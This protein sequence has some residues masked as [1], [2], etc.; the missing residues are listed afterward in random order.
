MAF[1]KYANAVVQRPSL[2]SKDWGLIR[3]KATDSVVF[4]NKT[5]AVNLSDYSSDKYLLTHAT[6]IASVDVEN[7]PNVKVGEVV[8]NGTKVN[9]KWNDY[10]ITTDTSKYVNANLDAWDRQTLLNTYRT[11]IGAENFCEHVQIPELSKGKVIDAVAR[12]LGDTIYVDILVATDRKHTELIKDIEEGKVSTLSM[13]CFLAGTPITMADGTTLPIE[14]IQPGQ[15]VLTHKGRPRKVLNT[16][17]K[18]G[19]TRIYEISSVGNPGTVK[20]TSEHPFYVLRP[21]DKCACGCGEDLEARKHSCPV[22]RVTQRFKIGHKAR[23]LN[24]N[25]SMYTEDEYASRSEKIRDI[26]SLKFEWVNAEDLREGDYVAFPKTTHEVRPKDVDERMA[27]LMG[28]FLSEGNFMKDAKGNR[29]GIEFT[30][31]ITE[32]DTLGL[33]TKN[34]LESLTDANVLTYRRADRNTFGVRVNADRELANKMYDLCGEYSHGKRLR[35]DVIYWPRDLKLALIGAYLEGDGCEGGSGRNPKYISCATVSYDLWNQMYLILTS[36]GIFCSK[37]VRYNA[38]K[39]DLEEVL[40]DNGRVIGTDSRSKRPSF[41]LQMNSSQAIKLGESVSYHTG[42]RA[43]GKTQHLR[44]LEDWIIFP[45]TSIESY[46]YE[47]AVYNFEV[48]EDNSYVAFGHAVHNCSILFSRCSKCGNV[49]ADETELC[50]HIRYEKGNFFYDSNGKK[51]IVAELCGHS[52]EADSVTFIEASWVANPAFKGAVVRNLLNG[53]EGTDASSGPDATGGFEIFANST[54][55]QEFMKTQDLETFA[56]H[57]SQQPEALKRLQS[58][59]RQVLASTAKVSFGFGD[60]DEEEEGE[61][62]PPLEELKDDIK[63]KLREDIKRDLLKEMEE[64]MNLGPKQPFFEGDS[65]K[66]NTNNNIIE[67]YQAFSSKYASELK[68]HGL[69]RNVYT[70]VF[71]A[72]TEGWN[73]VASLPD[74]SN[75]D[76]VA[77]MYLRDRDFGGETL[78]QP[79]Y[80]CLAKVGGTKNYQNH[81]AFLNAC[82][83][84]LGRNVKASEAQILIKRAKVLK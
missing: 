59:M 6:I 81:H 46:D 15:E 32:E 52:E 12:D 47:G 56:R 24:P 75:R 54:L 36:L 22:K 69:L 4:G 64:D 39:T 50:S 1:L 34:L 8:E 83:L 42:G 60:D 21:R 63:T 2:Q 68:G 20:A 74:V 44:E 70:V 78:T 23:I 41:H 49:A 67:G 17:K 35:S 62:L 66:P 57:A 10:F 7:V 55:L 79:L 31:S 72:H 77:A 38:L 48:E 26:Q 71:T 51:R 29:V 30:F 80:S 45:V 28:Y 58:E 65:M 53:T 84:A 61:A 33:E 3:A 43:D 73:K 40:D 16:Q 13:G 25:V 19:K 82:S 14:K 76:I 18:S 11:F 9:R 5:A 37:Y 27:R